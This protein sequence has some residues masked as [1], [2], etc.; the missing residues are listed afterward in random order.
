MSVKVVWKEHLG[1]NNHVCS[2]DDGVV[3]SYVFNVDEAR[4]SYTP[5]DI[6]IYTK[7]GFKGIM[8]KGCLWGPGTLSQL[9]NMSLKFVME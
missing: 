9:S 3:I 6:E 7:K 1:R 8:L 2:F 4:A 5:Q